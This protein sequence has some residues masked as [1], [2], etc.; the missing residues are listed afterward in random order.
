MEAMT[1]II[2]VIAITAVT[3]VTVLVVVVMIV[4]RVI[5]AQ[6]ATNLATVT[7]VSKVTLTMIAT[8]LPLSMLRGKSARPMTT[9]HVTIGG[10]NRMIPMMVVILMAKI[11]ML[12][13]M[14]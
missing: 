7:V 12:N 11:S 13:P 1:A 10:S 3:I 6:I 9:R 8:P 5:A 4:D 2:L 14:V